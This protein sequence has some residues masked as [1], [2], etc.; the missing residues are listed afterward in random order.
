NKTDGGRDHIERGRKVVKNVVDHNIRPFADTEIQIHILPSISVFL[1][2]WTYSALI[3]QKSVGVQ[4]STRAA[5][6]FEQCRFT[7]G[8]AR[9]DTT[10]G[11]PDHIE[12]GR[13]VVKNVVDHNI[14]PFADTEIQIHILPSISVFLLDWTYSALIRQTS[15]GVQG[16]TRAAKRFEQCRFT[17]G[18]DIAVLSS[19]ERRVG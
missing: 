12:A 2:D 10:E 8:T 15:V 19:E 18:T 3:R 13:K 6:R 16:S 14:R 4:G 11:G 1:L 9:S 5:K 7:D 17:D